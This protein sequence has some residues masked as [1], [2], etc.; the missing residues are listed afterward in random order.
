MGFSVGFVAGFVGVIA[1]SHAAYSTTQC[2][3]IILSLSFL[4]LLFLIFLLFMFI[5]GGGSDKGLL[6][7][8]EDDFS[9]P[10]FNVSYPSLSLY[11]SFPFLQFLFC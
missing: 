8:T 4:L 9:G 2:L 3:H 5:C 6:K 7:N 10:P 11:F 1:L